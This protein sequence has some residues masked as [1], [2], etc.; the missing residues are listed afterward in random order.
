MQNI[1]VELIDKYLT[2]GY[3]FILS[4][5]R[6]DLTYRVLSAPGFIG[7]CMNNLVLLSVEIFN[8]PKIN[9]II[10]LI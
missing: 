6:G 9:I 3:E 10:F 2:T 4:T 7:K 8:K 5:D 1:R